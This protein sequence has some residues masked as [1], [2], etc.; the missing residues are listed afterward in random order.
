ML[1]S[2]SK[3]QVKN[4][5]RY[6]HCLGQLIAYDEEVPSSAKIALLFGTAFPDDVM[7]E[8][9]LRLF[10]NN[11][12]EGWFL[13]IEPFC[14]S[15]SVIV[16]PGL[17]AKLTECGFRP[18]LSLVNVRKCLSLNNYCMPARLLGHVSFLNTWLYTLYCRIYI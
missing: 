5:R 13:I 2:R 11:D 7:K 18:K 16:P 6:K 4:I 3:S 14:L 17:Q 8:A 12:I 9:I 15:S 10:K 1:I